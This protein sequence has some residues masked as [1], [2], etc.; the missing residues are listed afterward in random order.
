[1]NYLGLHTRHENVKCLDLNFLTQ[2]N[3]FT[4]KV[5]TGCP[6]VFGCTLSYKVGTESETV[7]R[8]VLDVSQDQVQGTFT[9]V[10]VPSEKTDP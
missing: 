2:E 10:S 9:D 3:K 5:L 7:A 8:P 4:K 6:K 1:M